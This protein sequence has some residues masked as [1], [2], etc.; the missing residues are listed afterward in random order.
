ML[1]DAGRNGFVEVDT[2]EYREDCAAGI[3]KPDDI[4]R[5][6]AYYNYGK[7]GCAVIT[8]IPPDGEALGT[9]GEC[10][11]LREV[12]AQVVRRVAEESGGA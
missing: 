5:R 6:I 10:G 2:V 11:G 7:L 8:G 9:A 4:C 12:C 3:K 1:F